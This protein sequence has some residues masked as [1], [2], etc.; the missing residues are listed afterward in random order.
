MLSPVPIQKFLEQP[1]TPLQSRFV[2]ACSAAIVALAIA[3]LFFGNQSVPRFDAYIPFVMGAMIFTYGIT[4]ALLFVQSVET[5]LRRLFVLACGFQF[6]A[7]IMLP[8]LAFYPRAFGNQSIGANVQMAQ[9][10]WAVWHASFPIFVV[11]AVLAIR[12]KF[13]PTWRLIFVLLVVEIA[14]TATITALFWEARSFLPAMMNDIGQTDFSKFYV[15]PVIVALDLAAIAILW[16]IGA[17]RTLLQQGLA[18]AT[19]ASMI[20]AILVFECARWSTGWYAGK[21]F[22]LVSATSVLGF[23]IVEFAQLTR[24][25]TQTYD[26]LAKSQSR[27]I[28]NA[29]AASKMKSEF[30]AVMSHEIRTPLGGVVGATE[31][32]MNEELSKDQRDLA[33]MANDA[34]Q[35]LMAVVN[36]VLDFS[37]IESGKMQVEMTTYDP[38]ALI[39]GVGA[40]MGAQARNKS[41]SLMTYV[42]PE[43]PAPLIGDP[44]RLR[45]I[46]VNLTGNAIKFTSA[47]FVLLTL[48]PVEGGVRFGVRDSGIG[49]TE[50][51]IAKLFQPFTQADASTTRKFGGTGLGL[52]ISKRLVDAMGGD[53]I[54]IDSVPGEGST[55]HFT[56]P[57]VAAPDA[58]VVRHDLANLRALVVAGDANTRDVLVRYLMSW[59]VRT[60]NAGSADEAL[61]T[62]R[63]ASESERFDLTIVDLGTAAPFGEAVG[64]DPAFKDLRIVAILKGPEHRPEARANGFWAYL[65]KPIRQSQLYDALADTGLVDQVQAVPRAQPAFDQPIDTRRVLLVDDNATNREI[66]R[67]QLVKMGCEV[68]MA[69]D[70]V[71]AVAAAKA[72]GY[73]LILMDC[74][75]PNLDGYGA[76]RQI[77][78]HESRTGIHTPIFGLTANAFAEDHAACLAAGMDYVLTK[79]LN[80]SELRSA[81]GASSVFAER[82]EPEKPVVAIDEQQLV[83]IFE[84]D[85]DGMISF[86]AGAHDEFA[87]LLEKTIAG[88]PEAAHSLKGGS[89]NAGAR[90]LSDEAAKIY[91]QLRAGETPDTADL[92]AAFERFSLAVDDYRRSAAAK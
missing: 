84:D 27:E 6:C 88:D 62:L 23:L 65:Q 71:E 52:T 31:L 83:D 7:L 19:L 89:A 22:A 79:P 39:E 24:Q 4:A 18:F 50:E 5:K 48:E 40:I 35:A 54:K 69:N 32:L 10:L 66:G 41:L 20:D 12:A 26:E 68:T 30:V 74:M 63:N 70:G 86:L 57:L 64:E 53:K 28:E 25:L 46:L 81:V 72:G 17:L 21:A 55:F 8:Y 49:I 67:R 51:Q 16:R 76:T 82:S 87:D 78:H 37:K 58:K 1:A 43:I 2:F 3:M 38:T 80:V 73:D 34:A 90:E 92:K 15:Q 91:A 59:H 9:A 60:A 13:V 42:D 33:V 14:A 29:V 45:Q 77:R 85:R 47:G 36:D 56:L 61:A 11:G 75:M 44:T